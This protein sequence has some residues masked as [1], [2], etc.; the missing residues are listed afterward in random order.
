MERLSLNLGEML[1]PKDLPVGDI[2]LPGAFGKAELEF[3][4][5]LVVMWHHHNGHMEEWVP[6]TRQQIIDFI[7][8]AHDMKRDPVWSLIKNP[9]FN[10]DP[11]GLRDKGWFSGW[12]DAT[13]P[14][15]FTEEGLKC[16]AERGYYRRSQSHE[17]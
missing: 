10:P 11:N 6:V 15:V 17:K 2:F 7:T 5:I 12:K 1:K 3:A 16:I 14:G 8:E 9:F 13:D 4:A